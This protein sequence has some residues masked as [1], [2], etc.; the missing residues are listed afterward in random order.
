ML[1]S[2]IIPAKNEEVNLV[3]C[4][5][6]LAQLDF[7]AEEFEVIVVDNGSTDRTVELAQAAGVKVY[8]KAE[9]TVAGLRNFGAQQ[10]SGA[11]LVFLDADCTVPAD[12]LQQARI[13][14]NDSAIVGFGSPPVVPEGAS[15][16]QKTWFLVRGKNSLQGQDVP[17]LESMN[18]FVRRQVF[19][20]LNGFNEELVTCEDY[21]LSLRLKTKGRLIS[22]RRIVAVHHGEAKNLAIFWRKERWRGTSNFKGIRSHQLTLRELPSLLIPVLYW[23]ALL[24]FLAVSVGAAAGRVGY[25]GVLGMLVLWQIPLL[26]LAWRKCGYSKG[27]IVLQLHVLL[28]VYFAARGFS[29]VGP[30]AWR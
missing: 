21:D 5:A 23:V 26:L 19:L 12:W 6:S 11:I 1:F 4:L 28:N 10:A 25:G 15:W 22:D 14:T 20:E 16:V 24:V 29:L 3:P 2:V 8:I 30:S 27:S 7:P 13:Y 18:L 9:L 17:W